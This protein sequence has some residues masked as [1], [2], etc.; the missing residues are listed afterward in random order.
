M[1]TGA[2]AAHGNHALA[3]RGALSVTDPSDLFELDL[4]LDLTREPPPT[5]PSLF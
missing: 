2:G 4:T 5:Q 3:R 1:W